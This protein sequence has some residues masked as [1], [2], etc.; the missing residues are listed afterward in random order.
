MILQKMILLCRI[1]QMMNEMINTDNDV[2]NT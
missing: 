1:E 2:P